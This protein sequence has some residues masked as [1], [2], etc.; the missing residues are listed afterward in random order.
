MIKDLIYGEFQIEDVLSDIIDTREVQRLKRIHQGGASYLVNSK[1]NGTRYDHSIGVMLLIRKLGGSI[2]EQ[3]AGL[4][5]DVSHTAFSHMIDY[6]L[7]NKEEDYHEKIYDGIIEKSEIPK[8]IESYGYDFRDILFNEE[9]W[10]ILEKSLPKLCADRVD[11]TLRDM[12][13]YEHITID[14]A[15]G[16]VDDLIVIDGEIVIKD[17]CY[18]EWF[19]EVYCKLVMDCFAHPL[20]IYANDIL[21]KALKI[22]LELKEI[23][24]IDFLEDDEF[25][26]NKLKNS[27]SKEVL[28]LINSLEN[29]VELEKNNIEYN[30]YQKQKIRVVNPTVIIDNKK[31][32]SSEKSNKIEKLNEDA[33]RI[34]NEGIYIKILKK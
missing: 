1:W 15:K 9:K 5:H 26:Y 20:N 31:F 12:I 14:E 24:L 4:L 13:T 33:Y 28:E 17:I 22:S 10:T 18:A 27:K 29:E 25:I 32:S 23:K 30:I 34:G 6:V 16:F 8:I 11:Y 21:K 2:E 7:E 3:I 19:V